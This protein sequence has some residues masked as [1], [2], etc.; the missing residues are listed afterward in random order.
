MRFRS[1]FAV[2][3]ALQPLAAG[4]QRPFPQHTRYQAPQ[5]LLPA[6]HVRSTLDDDVRMFY[7]HWKS[8]YLVKAGID[9]AGHALYRVNFGT[10]QPARTVSEGQG[11]GMLITA[12][13]AGHDPEAREIFDGLHA[14]ALAHPSTIDS[15]L[16]SWQVPSGKKSGDDSAF[17]GDADIAHALLLA[18]AQWGGKGDSGY[19]DASRIRIKAILE[20]TIGPQ[21]RLPLLG[22]WVEADG[23]KYNQFTPR[24][25]D[26]MPAHFRSWARFTQD[27]TWV[28]VAEKCSR[29]AAGLV[30][31]F[32][33]QCGLLPDFIIEAASNPRPAP[34]RFLEGAHDGDYY[35][36][37]GRVPW[38]I[39]SDALLNA[40]PESMEYCRKLSRWASGHTDETPA[41]L[42][43]G[44]RLNGA[45]LKGGGGF[46][47]F[48]AAP[49]GVAAML[50]PN[51][52][53]WLDAL[54]A[55]VRATR[56]DYF[57]DSV[58]LL[59][60]ITMTGNLWDPTSSR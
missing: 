13:M 28:T 15:R 12:L 2:L 37:A 3:L 27:E 6:H 32:S 36:N 17:D 9:P 55:S 14:F 31:G 26:F 41:K 58:N 47:T 54:Y 49:I 40:T 38:R 21:S 52:Q 59:C 20:S 30:D 4:P 46:T 50:D 5:S 16:M 19:A 11:Y 18:H 1:I 35:Y 42:H 24:S 23:R 51:G 33:P 22:D 39:G 7:Q 8:S 29:L 43:A 45:I 44:Y 60:M 53:T 25:S 34:P 57:E 48:F 10:R 56:E